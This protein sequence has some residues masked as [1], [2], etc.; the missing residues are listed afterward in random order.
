MSVK[1]MAQ[2]WAELH[3]PDEEPNSDDMEFIDAKDDSPPAND[4]DYNHQEHEEEEEEEDNDDDEED[5]DS[6]DGDDEGESELGNN[7]NDDVDLQ[8]K[9]MSNTNSQPERTDPTSVQS[10][11]RTLPIASFLILLIQS[12]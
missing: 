3:E 6:D 9:E 10:D 1:G 5:V 12:P 8:D 7:D 11:D 4:E 2:D